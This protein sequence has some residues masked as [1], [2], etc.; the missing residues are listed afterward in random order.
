MTDTQT[1]FCEASFNWIYLPLSLQLMNCFCFIVTETKLIHFSVCRQ[2]PLIVVHL[3]CVIMSVNTF[4][5]T[6]CVCAVP[7]P[8]SGTRWLLSSEFPHRSWKKE[9]GAFYFQTG[10]KCRNHLQNTFTLKY[11]FCAH[12][13]QSPA[14]Q[15]E[16][17]FLLCVSMEPD[18]CW[19]PRVW[20]IFRY[21]KTKSTT[22]TDTN[23]G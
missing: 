16:Q 5:Q 22:C 11:C 17:I 2:Q 21:W 4:I 23:T 7:A 15:Q 9:H 13:N 14:A 1:L 3:L 10:T 19:G 20:S 6:V 12:V 8:D 18:L